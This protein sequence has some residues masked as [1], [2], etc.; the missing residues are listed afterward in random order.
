MTW[1]QPPQVQNNT[2]EQQILNF[3]FDNH[4]KVS[5]RKNNNAYN[6]TISLLHFRWTFH[7]KIQTLQGSPQQKSDKYAR[8]TWRLQQTH[9]LYQMW[10]HLFFSD[11]LCD[12]IGSVL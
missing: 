2:V 12:E 11:L 4:L 10:S 1:T 7:P 8:Q 3:Y 9:A 6:W 5:Q